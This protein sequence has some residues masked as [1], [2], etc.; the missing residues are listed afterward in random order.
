MGAVSQ[1]DAKVGLKPSLRNDIKSLQMKLGSLLPELALSVLVRGS[2]QPLPAPRR[3]L[4]ED[5]VDLNGL[6]RLL[7]RLPRAE[8]SE[9]AFTSTARVVKRDLWRKKADQYPDLA[10][11]GKTPEGFC[12]ISGV[13]VEADRPPL[14]AFFRPPQPGHAIIL[15][16]HGLYDSKFNRYV[17]ITAQ[18]LAKQGFGILIPDMRWHG[19]LLSRQWLPTLGL[20]ESEDLL[21]WARWIKEK[22]PSHPVGLLGFSLGALSVIHALAFDAAMEWLDAGG[23]AICPPASLTGTVHNLDQVPRL[24]K[25][26][27][28]SFLLQAFRNWIEIRMQGLGI[29]NQSSSPFSH[30]LSWLAGELGMSTERFLELAD[31]EKA[32]AKCRRPLLI[33]SSTND[34]IFPAENYSLLASQTQGNAFVH[35]IATSGGHIGQLG[36]YPQWLAEVTHQFFHLAAGIP[37]SPS[38]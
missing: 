1:Y 36:I 32:L 22:H 28:N 14:H 37:Q 21:A 8:H 5:S 15:L 9:S 35:L 20:E 3:A 7:D 2:L 24:G 6:W 11:C 23:I 18:G 16:V 33:V 10:G 38:A 13:L 12:K 31:P 29:A 27:L 19:S 34:P 25:L 17:S 4:S 30:F 26:G